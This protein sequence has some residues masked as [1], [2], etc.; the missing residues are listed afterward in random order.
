MMTVR[1][2][3]RASET[4]W[5]SGRTNPI[6]VTVTIPTICPK[7]GGPRGEAKPLQQHDDGVSYT[8]DV[9]QN[10]CEHLDRYE[11]VVR[12]A[13]THVITHHTEPVFQTVVHDETRL[14]EADSVWDPAAT[15][16]CSMRHSTERDGTVGW[17]EREYTDRFNNDRVTQEWVPFYA[18]QLPG[19]T[20]PQRFCE[21]DARWITMAARYF[22]ADEST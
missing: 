9:W 2:R 5:G 7:C 14:Y 21:D 1:V 3:D 18:V 17:R 20:E 13:A 4:P 19:E 16:Q 12:E 8:T 10:P 6:V 11:D 22:L 15:F